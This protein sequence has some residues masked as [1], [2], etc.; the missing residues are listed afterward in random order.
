M[1]FKEKYNYQD[2]V[3]KGRVDIVIASEIFIWTL[4]F[5]SKKKHELL[6]L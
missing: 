1:S 6:K 2:K 3:S 4:K 5:T